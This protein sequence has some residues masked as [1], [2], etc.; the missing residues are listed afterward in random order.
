MS[1]DELVAR[2]RLGDAAAFEAV[3]DRYHHPLLG[4]CRH[5]LGSQAEAEDA[6]Q[7]VFIAAHRTLRTD[8]RHLQ[9]KSWLYA[10]AGNRCRS[11]LRARRE[12]VPLEAVRE[13]ATAGLALA[14]E[15]ERRE[16]LKLLLVDVAGLPEDQRAAL[17]LAELGDLAHDEI[18][19]TLDVRTDK[20][21][22]L[23][24]QARESLIGSRR[25]RDTDCAEIREQLATLR[26]GALRRSP[27]TRHLAACSACVAFKGE[28]RAQRAALGCV[29]PVAPA[30]ALKQQILSAAL[31]GGAGGA[32]S[33]AGG[34]AVTGAGSGGA[35][36][37]AS[38]TAGAAGSAVTA[39]VGAGSIAAGGAATAGLAAGS[40][41]AATKILAAVALTAGAVGGGVAIEHREQPQAPRVQSAPPRAGAP[42]AVPVRKGARPAGPGGPASPAAAGR[43]LS[44]DR[45]AAAPTRS[46]AGQ[47]PGRKAATGQPG[48]RG[49]GGGRSA[50]GRQAEPSSPRAVKPRRTPGGNAAA[51]AGSRPTA[52][53]KRP[54]R[55]PRAKEPAKPRSPKAA[56]AVTASPRRGAR[57]PDDLPPRATGAAAATGP[58]T[59]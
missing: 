6:L 28:V 29:L 20:V 51:P 7:H 41:A 31:A 25:A 12:D 23:V 39:G 47:T 26:G 42:A 2:V 34:L 58:T 55:K 27:I 5:M 40:V 50:G 46:R 19:A 1:D 13:P 24:F 22:A 15:V 48:K 21:K 33:T 35:A 45:R 54:L 30:L 9:L 56:P 53:E 8:E 18:A 16:E 38:G 36:A 32:A 3:Y 57:K 49:S 14:D 52:A 4:F 44:E 10:V 43:A 59:P 37:I 17:V 11:V